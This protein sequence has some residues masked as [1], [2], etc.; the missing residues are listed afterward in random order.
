MASTLK[1]LRS[2]SADKRPTASGLTDGQLAINTASGTPGLFFKD[3][4]SGIV[5]VGPAHVSA[6]APNAT[7][8]GSAGNSKGEFWVDI[9]LVPSGLKVWNGS[10]FSNLTPSGSETIPGLL[11]V[12]TPAEVQ[13]GTDHQ[14]AVTP[15]GL[16][17]K[18]SDSTATTSSTTIASSTAVKSAYDLANAALPK[19][20]GTVTGELLISPSG[21]LVFEGSSDD[22]FETTLAVTNPTADRTITFPNITG[23]VITGA[24]VGTVTSGMILDGTVG[25]TEINASAAIAH[26]KLASLTAGNILLGNAS[27]VP[28]STAVTG[29]IT[30]SNAGVTAIS[31]GVIVNAD[32]AAGAAIVDTKLATIATA[33]KVSLSALNIDGATD[34]G[35]ALVNGDLFIVDDGAGGTNRKAQAFRMAQLTY[36]GVTGDITVASGGTAAISAGVIVNA[37]ISDTAEIA[38]S[39]LADGAARQLLQTDAAGTGVEWASNIDIPGTLDVTSAATFDSSVAVTGTLTK[40]GNNVV[41]VGDT[42]T[43]TSAMIADGTIVNGDI[44][45]SA[46]IAGTKISP[47]FGSQTI[48]TTGIV[49]HALGTQGAPTITFTGDTNTGIYSPGADQ[50]AISTGGSERV[51]F[52]T[53]EVVFNDSGANYDFR[54]EGDTDANLLLVDASSDRVGIGQVNPLAKLHV[55]AANSDTLEDLLRLEQFNAAGTDNARLE[56]RADAANNLVFYASTGLNSG[57]HVFE[58][59][60]T[61]R[62]R[63]DT[64]GRLLVGT[65]TS[66]SSDSFLQVYRASGDVRCLVDSDSI[67]NTESAIFRAVGGS[68]TA[69]FGVYK[70]SGITNPCAFFML[71]EEDGTNQLYWTDNSGNLRIST[72]NAHIGTTSGTVVGTQTSDE[73]L[74]N[75]IGPVEYGLNT[76]KQIEPVR[77]T[78]KSEPDVEKLGFIAQQ[79][80]P[81]V[82]Q[83]IFDT[84]EHIEGE[85]EDAPT[86]LG[87]EYVA[88][89]PVLVN[90][91]KELSNKNDALEA[92]LAALESA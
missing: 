74:K 48:A 6:T 41:T 42:G 33:D 72:N 66:L 89:I 52:G 85:P 18:I 29:D 71:E 16:Q 77:Y 5:K 45:A 59:G 40:S 73:R 88:L 8:A 64:S 92:R 24:D 30:I 90:A 35:G 65:P 12:A 57:G 75:I 84:N 34:I 46:A 69:D 31:A 25:N 78:L 67:G 51:E 19:A 39:K 47:D 11:E 86:K 36:S 58:T 23:T 56:I 20:G 10:A 44:N 13:T 2:S 62:V 79:V 32:I 15:S 53:S 43:V 54:V 63:I 87:M 91:I 49:S 82:P 76:L 7:P 22:G 14:R 80:Q 81:L 26:S 9:N 70:H 4:N 1:H 68:R 27:N 60:N 3:S 21:S 37:D 50:V 28:T 55:R 61:E 38:V 17:S 83:S